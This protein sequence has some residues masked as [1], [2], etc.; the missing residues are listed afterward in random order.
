[1]IYSFFL[2]FRRRSQI[3]YASNN[4]QKDGRSS[5]H[6][7]QFHF[8]GVEIPNL[9]RPREYRWY[10]LNAWSPLQNIRYANQDDLAP[11]VNPKKFRLLWL[12]SITQS[13]VDLLFWLVHCRFVD[14]RRFL[15]HRWIGH[16]IFHSL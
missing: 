12:F 9:D 16:L 7:A 2:A 11:M 3:H 10:H 6:F 1:M 14:W 5:L 13:Q 8:H 15:I 4:L